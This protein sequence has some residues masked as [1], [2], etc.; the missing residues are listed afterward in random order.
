MSHARTRTNL[1]RLGGVALAA[2]ATLGAVAAAGAGA[3]AATTS[4]S[5]GS[6][7]ASAVPT[8]LAGIRAKAATDVTDRVNALNA[9]IAKVNA[10]KGL[11]TGQGTLVSYLGNDISPLQQLNQTIQGDATVQQ[12]AQDFGKIFTDYRVYVLVLPASRIAADADRVTTTAIPA[13]TADATKAQSH[14]NPGNQAELQPLI[15]DLNTQISTAANATNG[16]AGTVLANT[17]AQWNANNG[18]LAASR[19]S[20]RAAA[21]AIKQGRSD[22]RQ[23]VQELKGS[24]TTTTG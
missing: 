6:S 4:G 17:A 13:L 3:G 24:S 2:G 11:G 22:V 12:A 18:L 15:N 23:I 20:D 1:I 9:A 8:T 14:V 16:L 10:A 19:S 7:G 21:A 5:T